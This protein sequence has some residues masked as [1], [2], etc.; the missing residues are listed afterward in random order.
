MEPWAV[1]SRVVTGLA[2]SCPRVS[3]SGLWVAVDSAKGSLC[4]YV[5]MAVQQGTHYTGE[6]CAFHWV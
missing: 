5:C 3:K 6:K 1:C 2:F 4:W